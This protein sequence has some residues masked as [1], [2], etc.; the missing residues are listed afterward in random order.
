M[1]ISAEVVLGEA[2]SGDS[3]TTVELQSGRIENCCGT[4]VSYWFS[5]SLRASPS[6]DWGAKHGHMRGHGPHLSSGYP[7]TGEAGRFRAGGGRSDGSAPAGSTSTSG[8]I[9]EVLLATL[10]STS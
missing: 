7:R 8:L 10:S 2:G 1:W 5:G 3:G 9:V 6:S 4:P